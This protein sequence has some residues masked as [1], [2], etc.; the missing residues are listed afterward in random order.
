MQEEEINVFKNLTLEFK[1][2]FVIDPSEVTMVKNYAYEIQLKEEKVV[3]HQPNRMSPQKRAIAQEEAGKCW[4]L[5]AWSP[6]HHNTT[7][8]WSSWRNQMAAGDFALT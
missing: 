8:V 4:T 1:D 3:A 6:L 2:L 7:T 5:G